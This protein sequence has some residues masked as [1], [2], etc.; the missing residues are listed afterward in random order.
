[1]KEGPLDRFLYQHYEGGVSRFF[2]PLAKC[3]VIALVSRALD[4]FPLLSLS[5]FSSTMRYG[6]TRRSGKLS[7]MRKVTSHISPAGLETAKEKDGVETRREGDRVS[8]SPL[9]NSLCDLSRSAPI[10]VSKK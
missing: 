2:P 10:R 6:G 3:Y 5:S 1:M 4:N 7:S 9:V 8:S